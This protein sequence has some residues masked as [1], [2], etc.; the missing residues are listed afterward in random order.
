MVT[1]IAAAQVLIYLGSTGSGWVLISS[2]APGET[3][4]LYA[5][6]ETATFQTTDANPYHLF[7]DSHFIARKSKPSG[8]LCTTGFT[9]DLFSPYSAGTYQ[10]G[11]DPTT[12]SWLYCGKNESSAPNNQVT[13]WNKVYSTKY[14]SSLPAP[15]SN[16]FTGYFYSYTWFGYYRNVLPLPVPEDLGFSYT[17]SGFILMYGL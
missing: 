15:C 6:S 5:R 4:C 10:Y 17:E 14:K 2:P 1:N 7:Q 13:D 9:P 16:Y 12:A 11:Y 3:K 8:Q